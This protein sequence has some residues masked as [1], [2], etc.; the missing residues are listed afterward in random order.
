MGA[1]GLYT[2]I[3]ANN[4][5]S[6]LLLAGFPVLLLVIVYFLT[7]AGIG[8]GYL[9]PPQEPGG[10]LAEAAGFM[11]AAAPLALIVSGVWF[12]IAYFANQ[13][14]IDLA[15]GAHQVTRQEEP[16]L[17]NLLENLCISRG[18]KTPTLR[19]IESEGLNAF[20]TGLNEKQY[21]ITVTRGLMQTMTKDEL[22]AV[23]GHELTHVLNRDVRTMVIASVFAGIITLIAQILYRAIMWGGVGRGRGDRKGGGPWIFVA[24][25]AA[26]IGYVL[27]IVIRMALSRSR[28]FVADAGSVELTKNPDAMISALQKISGHA[29]LDAP[30]SVRA[31]FLEDDSAGVMGLFATHPPIAKRIE[32]LV[33]FAGGR[34]SELPEPAAAAVEGPWGDPP[35]SPPPAAG[36]WG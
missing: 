23:L 13:T 8:A 5:R 3:Q 6:A 33:K 22:E 29:H 10:E 1:V 12:V 19:I 9:P 28:E 20:A 25:I 14:I 35:A 21:S 16:E 32:A 11:L 30:E 36:P 31:M 17:Y 27:A 7:L 34:V 2:H 18:I 24:L 15:T 4:V 26:A